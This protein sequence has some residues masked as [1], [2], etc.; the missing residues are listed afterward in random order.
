VHKLQIQS[1]TW[2]NT[3]QGLFFLDV[4][5]SSAGA[6]EYGPVRP[7]LPNT[8]QSF[9]AFRPRTASATYEEVFFAMIDCGT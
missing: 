3:G 6:V 7:V 8:Y 4:R 5:Q 1:L 9:P 2:F